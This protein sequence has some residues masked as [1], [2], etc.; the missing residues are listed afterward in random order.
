[1][2]QHNPQTKRLKR[3]NTQTAQTQR[4]ALSKLSRS[5]IEELLIAC[6][7]KYGF[8]PSAEHQTHTRLT[9]LP[10]PFDGRVRD[11]CVA[12]K[13]NHGL[14]TQCCDKIG[15]DSELCKTCER[16]EAR[17][18]KIGERSTAPFPYVDPKGKRE[19]RYGNVME[20]LGITET[21][22]KLAA[23]LRGITIKDEDFEM[24]KTTRGRPKKNK[25]GEDTSSDEEKETKKRGRPAKID[26]KLIHETQTNDLIGALVA[27]SKSVAESTDLAVEELTEID[28]GDMNEAFN[29][30]MGVVKPPAV[31]PAETQVAG[32]LDEF[33]EEIGGQDLCDEQGIMT[34]LH[35][36]LHGE[37]ANN[38]PMAWAEPKVEN[39]VNII[40]DDKFNAEWDA[41]VEQTGAAEEPEAK[42]PEAKKPKKSKKPKLT[43]EERGAA[44]VAKAA[45]KEAAKVAKADARAAKRA[46]EKLVKA[47]A[48]AAEKEAA[49]VIKAEAKAAAKTAKVAAKN[50][51]ATELLEEVATIQNQS[52]ELEEGEIEEEVKSLTSELETELFETNDEDSGEEEEVSTFTHGG[53]LYLRSASN[54]L[55]EVQEGEDGK[56][57][58]VGR[59]NEETDTIEPLSV[60]A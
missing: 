52:G 24:I 10:L 8:D 37:E 3:S 57:T 54:T 48:R 32:E 30:E 38:I 45:E 7:S 29:D 21:D 13:L 56:N 19:T 44:K 5:K 40:P 31:L 50:A 14:F 1:M 46:A 23:E 39:K 53:M 27:Q 15:D 18:G 60:E 49:K 25:D 11:G 2:S 43:E 28:T 58:P 6:G 4:M 20:K 9:S 42:E 34:T 35:N 17:Y 16:G 12:L 26:K 55:Y 33:V 51:E 41:K 59:Y 47:E 22:A 36:H